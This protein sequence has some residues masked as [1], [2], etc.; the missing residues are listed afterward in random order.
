MTGT[1]V[2]KLKLDDGGTADRLP[3]LRGTAGD[4][5]VRLFS[6]TK[7]PT[8]IKDLS[9]LE[10]D[11]PWEYKDKMLE[12]GRKLDVTPEQLRLI[13]AEVEDK[14]SEEAGFEERL[15]LFLTGLVEGSSHNEFA[16]RPKTKLKEFGYRLSADKKVTLEGNVDDGL[17]FQMSAGEVHIRGSAGE[18]LGNSM[19]G[20]RIIVDGYADEYCGIGMQGGRIDVALG[21]IRK[22]DCLREGGEVWEK[23]VRIFPRI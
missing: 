1:K 22:H 9:P 19:T 20:G 10:S 8:E 18:G 21:I 3:Q 7:M 2:V 14:F 6:D 16:L 15:G 11:C 12:E 17:C 5:A 13:L 4:R 23:G